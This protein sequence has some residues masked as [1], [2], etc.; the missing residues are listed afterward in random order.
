M[1]RK[2]L[3]LN[4]GRPYARCKAIVVLLLGQIK[5]ATGFRQFNLRG[6]PKVSA[7]WFLVSAGH[8]LKTLF[9]ALLQGPRRR[10]VAL[11]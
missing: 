11:H 9:R 7:E 6:H 10:E 2:V 3:T 1:R 5:H 8:N 4:G